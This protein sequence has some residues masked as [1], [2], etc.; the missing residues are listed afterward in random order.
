MRRRVLFV[1]ATMGAALALPGV[2]TAQVPQDSV[3]GSGTTDSFYAFDLD[4]RS[5]PSG[6]DPTGTAK[7]VLRADPTLWIE[8]PVTCLTVTGNRA[9]V[10]LDNSL[11]SPAFGR[12]WLIEVTDGQPDSLAVGLISSLEPPTVCPP[13]VGLDQQ[14]VDSGDIAVTDAPPLPASKDQCHHGGWKA[15]G[16]FKNQGACV[17]FVATGGRRP[18]GH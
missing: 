6:E 10:G 2:S 13:S 7:I 14:P 4:A 12:G 18:P 11:G 8:G 9:V 15:Y 1:A 16:V 3:A 17:S 5:G